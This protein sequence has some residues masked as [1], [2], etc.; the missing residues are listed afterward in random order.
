MTNAFE[1][2]GDVHGQFDKLVALLEYL[3]YS[4]SPL[5]YGGGN[6][7]EG[8]QSPRGREADRSRASGPPSSSE[9][10]DARTARPTKNSG[11][12]C[13]DYPSK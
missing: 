8:G 4:K 1:H 3:G 13:L 9:R 6:G 2:Q 10:T 11:A 5:P 12:E 7:N